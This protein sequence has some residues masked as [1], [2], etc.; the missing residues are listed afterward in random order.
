MESSD[1][2]FTQNRV[3]FNSSCPMNQAEQLSHQS[4]CS[5]ENT[6]GG[7]LPE[8]RPFPFGSNMTCETNWN[9]KILSPFCLDKKQKTIITKNSYVFWAVPFC[10]KVTDSLQNSAP[11]SHC[12]WISSLPFQNCS[13]IP[14]H[15]LC[16]FD[17]SVCLVRSWQLH[18]YLIGWKL[19]EAKR[20]SMSEE[21]IIKWDNMI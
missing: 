9:G 19:K 12:W 2:N 14:L 1:R 3:Q 10:F 8:W 13:C 11:H 16:L 15:V 21:H 20:T 4:F 17:L 5:R 7:T 6:D 18:T